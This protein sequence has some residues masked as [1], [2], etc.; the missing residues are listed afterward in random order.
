MTEGK[1]QLVP[2][3]TGQSH[4]YYHSII[5]SGIQTIGE[6]LLIVEQGKTYTEAGFS[7][8]SDYKRHLADTTEYTIRH[9]NRQLSHAETCQLLKE[10]TGTEPEKE[11]HSRELASLT[12]EKKVQ[13]WGEV[14]DRVHETHEPVTTGL[15]Q[16]VKASVVGLPE[17]KNTFAKTF[18]RVVKEYREAPAV[19]E[20]ERE[21]LRLMIVGFLPEIENDSGIVAAA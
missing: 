6:A 15:I 13:V 3:L 12:N 21:E 2:V 8:F 19:S 5:V 17:R 7:S 20:A 11:S 18:A 10:E 16:E 4:D 1:D 9:V 14:Q